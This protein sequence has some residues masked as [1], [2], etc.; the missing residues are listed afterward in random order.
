MEFW[1]YDREA[2]VRCPGCGWE[3]RAAEGE[4]LAKDLLEV[5]CPLCER[6]LRI[7]PFPTLDQTRA[8]ASAGNPRAQAELSG[9]DRRQAFLDRAAEV[10]LK[11][12]DRLPD[13]E[14]DHIVIDWDF[15][16]RDGEGWTVLRHGDREM[17][18]ERAYYEGA[19]RFAAVFALLH[20][21]YGARLSAV[22][23]TR[24]SADYLFG[25]D[26]SAPDR[27]DRLNE[28]LQPS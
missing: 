12:S 24:E 5:R 21:R 28:S 27:I 8:A 13:L 7:I 17:W 19:D 25:D 18:R 9:V 16:E 14:G 3:G 23:P 26:W 10:E 20:D 4:D 22:R 6:M 1:D 15:E 2:R 11:S